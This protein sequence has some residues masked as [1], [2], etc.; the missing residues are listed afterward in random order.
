MDL[1]IVPDVRSKNEHVTVFLHHL[2][3]ILAKELEP[4][5]VVDVD[6]SFPRVVI[7]QFTLQSD[8]V[9]VIGG[10]HQTDLVSRLENIGVKPVGQGPLHCQHGAQRPSERGI[11]GKT[12]Y[13]VIVVVIVRVKG[14]LMEDHLLVIFA[15]QGF[16]AE[17]IFVTVKVA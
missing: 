9:P 5:P 14:L 10:H 1:L 13:L 15:F 11:G 2:A 12:F 7:D 4:G 8:P 6:G 16:Q 17:K 3:V